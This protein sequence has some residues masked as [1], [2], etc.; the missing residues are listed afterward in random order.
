MGEYRFWLNV[1]TIS[2]ALA[3]ISIIL[4]ISR[5]VILFLMSIQL[6]HVFALKMVHINQ[7]LKRN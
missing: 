4:H 1:S 6:F 7:N 3:D 2:K 5:L